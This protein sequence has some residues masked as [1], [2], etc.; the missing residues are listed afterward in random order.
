MVLSEVVQPRLTARCHFQLPLPNTGGGVWQRNP[1]R[2]LLPHSGKRSSCRRGQLAGYGIPHTFEAKALTSTLYDRVASLMVR[3]KNASRPSAPE[4][5]R[6]DNAMVSLNRFETLC[7]RSPLLLRTDVDPFVSI[8]SERHAE[9]WDSSFM[10]GLD[11]SK[12]ELA[13]CIHR[14]A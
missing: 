11:L 2:S 4:G 9:G 1:K 12:W 10:F 6:T 5:Y 7:G 14:L 3:Y 13:V 8:I